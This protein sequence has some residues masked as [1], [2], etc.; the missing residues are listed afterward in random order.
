VNDLRQLPPLEHHPWFRS[1]DA[2]VRAQPD[3]FPG[4][5]RHGHPVSGRSR[6]D[7]IFSDFFPEPYQGKVHQFSL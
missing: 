4:S 2:Y 3:Y 5:E 6:R 1:R 7:I